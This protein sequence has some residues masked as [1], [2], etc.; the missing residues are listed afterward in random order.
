MSNTAKSQR[1]PGPEQYYHSALKS[2]DF[3]HDSS[4]S[5]AVDLLQ[6]LYER[7]CQSETESAK[8]IRV[9]A[10]LT[11]GWLK[12][13]FGTDPEVA[14]IRGLYFWGGVGRGKTFLMDIFFD[15]LPF[16]RKLRLHFHRFMRLIHSELKVLKGKPDPLDKVAEKLASQTRVLCLDEFFV[17]DITDAMILATLLQGL[18]DRGVTLVTTSN[19]APD[20]LY[21][22]G[23][24]RARFLPA[25]ELLKTHTTVVNIDAGIDYRLR[26][27]ERVELYHSATA[28]SEHCRKL[29]ERNF[30]QLVADK[31]EIERDAQLEIESRR[32]PVIAICEDIVWFDFEQICEGPRSQNDYIEIAREFHTVLISCVPQ[33]ENRDDAARRFVNLIDEFYDRNVNVILSAAAPLE[34]LYQNGRLAFE[35]QRTQSRLLEMQSKQYLGNEHKP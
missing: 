12:K 26:T 29:M 9:P 11:T 17:T 7:L 18:F 34:Q 32:I 30:L 31:T 6:A 4:Q 3:L 22:D 25:I 16:E 24:Q 27:L 1:R 21:K 10:L 20:G 13:L 2:E 19:I 28:E 14:P 8:R 5:Y 35:F 15:A 23:L 33:F